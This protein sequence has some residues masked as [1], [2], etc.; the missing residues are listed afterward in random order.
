M[1]ERIKTVLVLTGF[2][3][4]ISVPC[5]YFFKGRG[6]SGPILLEGAG[7]VASRLYFGVNIPPKP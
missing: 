6:F 7:Y 5:H 1:R 2:V 3:P 4:Q